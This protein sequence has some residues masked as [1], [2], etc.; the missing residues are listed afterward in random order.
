MLAK[1]YQRPT[2]AKK[3][4]IDVGLKNPNQGRAKTSHGQR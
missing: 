4:L 1:K 2:S 3:N